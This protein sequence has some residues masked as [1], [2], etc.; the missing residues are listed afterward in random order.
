MYKIIQ[1]PVGKKWFDT[2]KPEALIFHCDLG[3]MNGTIN[4]IKGN[5]VS[6]H[7]Y[8]PKETNTILQFVPENKG[9]WHCG[10]V[11][12]NLALKVFELKHPNKHS[13]GVCF[14]SRPIDRNGN[15]TYDWGKAYDGEKAT[16]SQ[17]KRAWWLQKKLGLPFYA[18]RE[19]TSY[20][21]RCVL[22]FK[23]RIE[24]LSLIEKKI[25]ELQEKV[26]VLLKQILQKLK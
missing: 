22:D 12:T 7:Y 20:K 4:H 2:N 26:V 8:I 19:M 6:Y 14:E 16:Q 1:V 13:I 17:V 9:A 25:I 11:N 24:R 5:E 21:P 10:F 3:T 15:L 18:H 23:K